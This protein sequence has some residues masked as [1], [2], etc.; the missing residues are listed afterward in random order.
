MTPLT[1]VVTTS[2]TMLAAVPLVRHAMDCMVILLR[3][4]NA[5]PAQT[6]AII[7]AMRG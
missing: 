3:T 5:T 1:E 7:R 6:A 2:T 4:R